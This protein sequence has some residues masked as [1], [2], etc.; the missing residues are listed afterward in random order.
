MSFEDTVQ[1]LCDLPLR[2]PLI[3]V[4]AVEALEAVAR[5]EEAGLEGENVAVAVD[6]V[7]GVLLP[8]LLPILGTKSL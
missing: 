8:Q 3:V 2:R 7:L 4:V 5:A 6:Y 1:V